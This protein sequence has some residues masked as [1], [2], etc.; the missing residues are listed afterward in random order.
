MDDLVAL[1]ALIPDEVLP[2]YRKKR[3]Y[4]NSIM[5]INETLKDSPYCKEAFSR[6]QRGIY[7]LNP[8]LVF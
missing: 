2:P 7:I 1:A 4:I 5:A 8:N 3:S 6:V